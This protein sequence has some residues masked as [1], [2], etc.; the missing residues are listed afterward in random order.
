MGSCGQ[1]ME[2]KQSKAK[3]MKLKTEICREK[4][5]KRAVLSKDHRLF[6]SIAV[7]CLVLF[8][9]EGV[10]EHVPD[11]TPGPYGLC[12]RPL[13]TSQLEGGFRWELFSSLL[14]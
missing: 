13:F 1:S 11:A 4:I 3:N 2:H 5:T 9:N 6:D 14:S 8:H 10:G 12:K 7:K